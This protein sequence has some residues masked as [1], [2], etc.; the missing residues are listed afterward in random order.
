LLIFQSED[1]KIRL[2]VHFEDENIWLTAKQMAELFGIDISGIRK[3]LK[4]VF[5]SGEL[6]R[7]SVSALFASTASDCKTYQVEYF[8]LDAIISVGYRVNSVIGTRF[9]I[10]ATKVLR[11]Y[12]IKGFALDDERL[13]GNNTLTDHFDELL[14]R[15]RDIRASEKR[16]YLRVREIF[17]MATDY[18]P[19]SQAA[20][21][22]FATMQ[23]KMHFAAT[24]KTAAEIVSERCDANKANLGL[25]NWKGS[26]VRKGDVVI[27]KNYLDEKEIDILN[28]IVVM[29]LDA[30]E[31]RMLRRQQIH[32]QDW[33]GYLDKFLADNELPVLEGTGKISHEQAKQLA[34]TAYDIYEQKRRQEKEAEAEANYLD[35]LQHSVK[36]VAAKRKKQ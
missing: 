11:E 9:R 36:L 29:W 19:Q 7:E 8:N 17:A 23:N 1:G 28:R 25:T 2:D 14:A 33:D 13:K 34:E 22:F 12:I 21:L 4:N 15:I 26:V 5:E 10:W 35:S 30:A 16:A 31:F 20:Q 18:D 32:T 24:G 27:A 3:H 6:T